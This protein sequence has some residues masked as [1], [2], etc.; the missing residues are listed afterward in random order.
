MDVK[1]KESEKKPEKRNWS[2]KGIPNKNTAA[3]KDMILTAL[4]ESGGV[5][6]LVERANDP[7]TAASF[8]TLIG[9]VLPTTLA[10]DP[11]APMKLE[12]S[13]KQSES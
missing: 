8:L 9:K 1:V 5:D 10:T 4:Q 7:R 11:N 13:W 6:Y 3:L 12:V 2:R